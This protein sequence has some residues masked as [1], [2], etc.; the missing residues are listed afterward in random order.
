MKTLGTKLFTNTI[1]IKLWISIAMALIIFKGVVNGW[2][3]TTGDFN[4]YYVSAKLLSQG[5]SIHQFYDN[6]WF[7]GEAESMGIPKGAKFS[8]FPPV[9]AY[10]YLP[11][12]IFKPLMAKRIWL[13]LNVLMLVILPFRIRKITGW[14]LE[15][16]IFFLSL[17]TFPLASCI[18]LGQLYLFIGF[19]LME[20]FGQDYMANRTKLIGFLMGIVTALK[21]LPIIFLGYLLKHKKRMSILAYTFL[22]IA[23]PTLL[24]Y[25]LD[26]AA[27]EAFFQHFSS[28]IQGNV[29]GQGKYAVA[30][31]SI[32]SLLNNLF[33]YDS[34]KNPI[35]IVNQPILKP[36]IK[37]L[38]IGIILGCMGVVY[39]KNHYQLTP[40]IVSIGII[41][42]FVLIPASASYHFLLLLWPILYLFKWL[43]SVKSMQALIIVSAL[44][45]ITLTI[46][47]DHIPDF[48]QLPTINLLLHYPRFWGLLCVFLFLSYYHIKSMKK[49]YG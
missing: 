15:R 2:N 48:S 9:T 13:I 5:A 37:Y 26:Q 34:L 1:V 27:Y 14:S 21:Y 36:L 47:P 41:G 25:F 4:N 8:P 35:P 24:V 7:K 49:N 6:D 19:L 42:V 43:I 16:A 31:Q 23:V 39:K 20:L 11:L 46:R 29:P 12:T 22:G 32:D 44:I 38:F 3:T 17:F 33:V 28:H 30:F 45:F 40:V 10:V 18:N